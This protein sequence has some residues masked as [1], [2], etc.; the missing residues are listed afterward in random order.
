MKHHHGQ[1]A[2]QHRKRGLI[3]RVLP[4]RNPDRRHD[5]ILFREAKRKGRCVR[6]GKTWYEF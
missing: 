1:P 3:F 4:R 5:N 6:V 2:R